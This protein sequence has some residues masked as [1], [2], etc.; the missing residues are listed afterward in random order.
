MN[1]LEY[2]TYLGGKSTKPSNMCRHPR[3]QVDSTAIAI[4]TSAYTSCKKTQR[5]RKIEGLQMYYGDVG[6][7]EQIFI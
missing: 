1:K 3:D 7:G 2:H 5:E 6:D 4:G